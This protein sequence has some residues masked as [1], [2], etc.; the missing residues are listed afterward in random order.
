MESDTLKRLVEINIIKQFARS[1]GA[2]FV[3]A[4]V[5]NRHVH[6]S[7][8]D[9]WTLFGEGYALNKMRDLNQPGQYACKE[10][11]ALSGPKGSVQQIRVLGP[12]RRETQVEI[13]QTDS[14]RL[15]IPPVVRM[16][17]EL[18]GT[19]GGRLTGPAGEVTLSY[20]VIVAARH[21]HMSE[22][23]AQAYSLKNGDVVSVKKSGRREIIFGNVIVRVGEGHSL[24]VHIDTDE[25][26]AAGMLCGQML[27]L[28]K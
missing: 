6:L 28:L 13:S 18:E 17:G 20:G 25:A 15:G 14:F 5:S 4:A 21:L 23:E 19:P 26:N 3:P 12:A 16:S 22:E 9:I 7:E 10:T 11:I 2:Y 8:A 24:E 27:E 1:A